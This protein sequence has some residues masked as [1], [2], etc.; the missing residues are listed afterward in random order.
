MRK[1]L[2]S[3]L[4]A[5]LLGA[6]AIGFVQQ[7]RGYILISLGGTVL[8]MS[9]WLGALIYFFSTL[10]LL[11]LISILRW[12]LHA[13]GIRSWWRL[14]R[15]S[16]HMTK[17]ASGLLLFL[18]KDWQKSSKLLGQAVK[19][20]EIP[21]VNLLY[22]ATAAAN[23]KQ[24]DQCQQLI[25]RLKDEFPHCAVQA[26]LVWAQ[27]LFEDGQ[28]D[29][30]LKILRRLESA[31]S[32][33]VTLLRLMSSL[34]RQQ[35]DWAT[36]VD[37]LPVLKKYLVH[38]KDD[39]KQLE[40]EIYSGLLR[41]FLNFDSEDSCAE[42]ETLWSQV[43]KQLR[44]QTD[45]LIAY[46]D[47]LSAMDNTERG[48]ALLIKRLETQW[49]DEL[50]T[51]FAT[52]PMTDPKKQLTTAEKW[53]RHQPENPHLL[54]TLGQICLRLAFFGKARDYLKAAIAVAPS[55]QAYFDLASVYGEMGKEKAR[56]E[57]YQ[58]GLA[59]TIASR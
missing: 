58:K 43:P 35:E 37:L 13:R 52:L 51:K 17:T 16:K 5:L 7:D 36:L 2:L 27:L 50:I 18:E 44:Q 6:V 54:M 48:I 30:A 34:Y 4:F 26:D 12:L 47:A 29:H 23:N 19:S 11:A 45:I 41:N 56:L 25:E 33:N 39:L 21:Q 20:S 32:N 46:V 15:R 9:F 8:E 59:L 28:L 22:A 24:W 31:N 40:T 57:A 42:L 14:R 53:L 3:S 38:A 1:I 49:Q 10:F 55:A